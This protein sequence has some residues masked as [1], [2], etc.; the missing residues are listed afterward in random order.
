L[1]IGIR[2]FLGVDNY[3]TIQLLSQQ[4]GGIE[5]NQEKDSYNSMHIQ[6]YCFD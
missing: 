1:L 4:K 3:R 6:K 2:N 5:Q